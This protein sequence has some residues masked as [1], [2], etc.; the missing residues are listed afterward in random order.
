MGR[1]AL[2]IWEFGLLFLSLVLF[3]GS[4]YLYFSDFHLISFLT[5][6]ES[7]SKAEQLGTI[8]FRTGEV[9]RKKA[10]QPDFRVVRSAEPVFNYD[11]IVTDSATTA[12]VVFSD[13]SSIELGPNTMVK[14]AFVS[15]FSLF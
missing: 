4:A 7:R 1:L 8:R 3:F 2:R 10:E 9:R 14:L 13:G 15:K 5:G 11:T 6:D 12:T